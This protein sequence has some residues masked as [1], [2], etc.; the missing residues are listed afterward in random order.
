MGKAVLVGL[1]GGFIGVI[2]GTGIIVARIMRLHPS[3]SVLDT[4]N[5]ASLTGTAIWIPILMIL[6]TVVASW[7]AAFQAIRQDAAIVLQGE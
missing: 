1:L 6:L 4:W 5:A 7:L 2:V 3:V